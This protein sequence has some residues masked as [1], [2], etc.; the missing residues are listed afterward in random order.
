[1]TL[2]LRDLQNLRFS[3]LEN[4]KDEWAQTARRLGG[5]N[6]RVD[7]HMRRPLAHGWSGEAATAAH[8][9]LSRLSDN[10]QFSG[11]ECALVQTTLD[12]AITELRAQQKV[13]HQALDAAT[14]KGYRVAPTGEVLYADEGDIPTG[15]PDAGVPEKEYERRTLEEDIFAALRSAQEIDARYRLALTRLRV[16]RGLTVSGLESQRD[17]SD[18]SK[19]AGVAVGLESTPAKGT[20]PKKVRDWWNGLSEEEREEQMALNPSVIGN[21]DGIPAKTRDKANRVNLDRLIDMYPPG[22]QLPAGVA[23]QHAGFELIRTRLERDA[24]KEPEP[25][26]LGI[27]PEGQGRAILSYGDPD[28]ADNVAAYVPGLNTQLKDVGGEDGDRARNVWDSAKDADGSKKT[29]SIVW[30]GY[31]A[32]QAG[33]DRYSESDLSITGEERGKQGGVAYGQFLDGIQAT[34]QGDRPHVTAIGHSYGS[35]TVG[36]AAQREGGIPADDIVLVGS[37][38]TGAQRAEQLG[39]GADHVWVGSAENDPVTHTPSEW[40]RDFGIA[41]HLVDPHE[42]HFGQD[43]A[44]EEFGGH[45]FGVADGNLASSHSNYFKEEGGPSLSNIGK[46][47]AG[48]TDSVT[49]EEER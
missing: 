49:A 20:D 48:R 34:H 12:G 30:L 43:P 26:L 46:I 45:R 19:I 25:L 40:E 10:F 5:Y 6:D 44:S 38:G 27:G 13:L 14:R 15:D 41:G 3:A 29:A 23:R 21:L 4:A 42:L 37:P 22:T 24:G 33:P 36:Q 39:V 17:A 35:F 8:K 16:G 18:I 9:R 32:P 1:M 11:E 7:A 31:D 28:T 47:V 2:T